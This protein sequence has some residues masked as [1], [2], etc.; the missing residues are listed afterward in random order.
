MEHKFTFQIVLVSARNILISQFQNNLNMSS[1]KDLLILAN[2]PKKFLRIN[3]LSG[4]KDFLFQKS[5]Y[6]Q[7]I[8]DDIQF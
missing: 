8:E 6:F 3:N 5:F 2:I 4:V 7:K 1:Q